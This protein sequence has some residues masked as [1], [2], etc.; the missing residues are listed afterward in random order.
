MGAFRSSIKEKNN[1]I[2]HKL[3]NQFLLVVV[4]SLLLTDLVVHE[5]VESLPVAL[6]LCCDVLILQNH[7][8]CSALPPL[9]RKIQSIINMW[10]MAF[11]GMLVSQVFDSYI[12]SNVD[13]L[14]APWRCSW[15]HVILLRYILFFQTLQV[16]KCSNQSVTKTASCAFL[17]DN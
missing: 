7:T 15:G 11:W 1:W 4:V 10:H 8:S 14:S 17:L 13:H 3:K 9:C 16:V 5:G 12:L 2:I 6:Y